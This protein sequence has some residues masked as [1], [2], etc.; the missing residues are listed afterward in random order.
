MLEWMPSSSGGASIALRST[1]TAPQSRLGDVPGVAEALHQLVRGVGDAVR[2]PAGGR[3]L[4]GE[5]VAGIE[6]IPTSKASAA[7][8]R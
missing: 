2:A 5:A 8:P 1:M 3:R 4:A 7:L 6:G